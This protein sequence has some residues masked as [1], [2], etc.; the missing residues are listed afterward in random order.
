MQF[1]VL[2][3]LGLLSS[4]FVLVCGASSEPLTESAA[5]ARAHELQ[6]YIDDNDPNPIWASFDTS[7]RAF[8][9][10][11][12][13][14]AQMLEGM[15]GQIGS[16]LE[17]LSENVD[18]EGGAPM[19]S[20]RCRFEKSPEPLLMTI[21]FTPDGLVGGLNIQP[22]PKVYP[23][24]KLDYEQQCELTVPFRGEW[25]VF[26]GGRTVE[27][28]YHAVSKTQRFAIDLVVMKD[29]TTHTGEGT[30]LGDY[31]AFGQ[32]LLAPGDGTVVEA[33]DDLPDQAIGASDPQNAYGNVVV[34]D[35]GNEEFSV[36]AHMKAGS[37]R[38]EAG[39]RVA[40]G[41]VI[42]LCGNSGN[43]SEPHIHFQLQDGPDRFDAEGLPVRFRGVVVD[44]GDAAVVELE[45]G[46]R[47]RPGE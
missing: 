36:V 29:G 7:M 23:S 20:A 41:D 39:N 12:L 25:F 42:G 30:A 32:E 40:R 1:M 26:W 24:T 4:S 13:R 6:G 22:E 37:V 43:T 9:G 16:L 27:Q 2:S 35:H 33:I 5:L 34:I 46:Q 45:K 17:I 14:F 38:V 15:K 28:N 18:A 10:D 31:F 8:V 11:S 19:Y 47:A 44:G 21:S 3:K